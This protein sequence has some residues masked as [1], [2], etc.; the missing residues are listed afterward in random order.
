MSNKTN[1]PNCGAPIEPYKCRCEFCGTW[2][3][4]FAAFDMTENVPYYVK[5]RT[6]A[7][8]ITTRA[9]PRLETI[10]CGCDYTYA[11]DKRGGLVSVLSNVGCDLNVVFHAVHDM[12]SDVLF[13][14][15]VNEDEIQKTD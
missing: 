9:I 15:E 1:C 6:P 3:F 8:V 12:N 10:E 2:Y 14:L 5:F 4:D 11:T 7:G 13:K